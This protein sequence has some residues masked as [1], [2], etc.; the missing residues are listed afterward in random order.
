MVN[1]GGGSHRQSFFYPAVLSPVRPDMRVYQEE[2]FGPLI[3][4]VP[5]RDLDEVIDYVRES[6]FGQQLSLFGNDPDEIGKLVDAFANQVGRIN[7]NAQC[8]RGPD[9]FP[10]NGRKNSAEGTLS[11]HDALRAF[12]IRTLVATRFQDDNKA[13]VSSIIRNRASGFLSTDYIL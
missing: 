13:L 11:V 10:F 5:Y 3:P 7:I 9:S 1:P 12:S 8:Q 4:V 2:Q 6:D